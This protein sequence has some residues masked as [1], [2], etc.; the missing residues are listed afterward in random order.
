MKSPTKERKKKCSVLIFAIDAGPQLHYLAPL[1][2]RGGGNGFS[3]LEIRSGLGE[4][5]KRKCPQPHCAYSATVVFGNMLV[6][7]SA[8]S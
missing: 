8:D 5:T 4:V 6:K 7:V 1:L 3:I 2:L